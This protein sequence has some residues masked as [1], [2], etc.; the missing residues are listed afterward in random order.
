MF[1]NFC[2]VLREFMK[3]IDFITLVIIYKKRK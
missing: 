2:R 3:D 1:I